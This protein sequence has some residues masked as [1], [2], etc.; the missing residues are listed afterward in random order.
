MQR[1]N[2]CP[3]A[4]DCRRTTAHG[5][6]ATAGRRG[7]ARRP[8]RHRQPPGR[9]GRHV[10]GPGRHA[11]QRRQLCR[12]RLRPP[13]RGRRGGRPLRATGPGLLEPGGRRRRGRIDSPGRLESRPI[14]RPRGRRD[15]QRRQDDHPADD[16]R[17]LGPRRWP[18]RPARTITTI[19]SACRS[20]CSGST[21]IT[22]MRCSKSR[23]AGRARS[24]PWPNWSG[25][26]SA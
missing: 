1:F 24:T 8:D 4:P 12:R 14:H 2:R 6:P 20:A 16:P 3:V 18:V 19:T 9:A 13:G 25:P 10:L 17:R 23:P 21:P 26:R 15:R 22:I 5:H 7:R 11:A